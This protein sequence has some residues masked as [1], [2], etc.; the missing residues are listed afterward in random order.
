[1][2]MKLLVKTLERVRSVVLHGRFSDIDLQTIISVWADHADAIASAYGGSGA[3]KSDFT[4]TNERTRK[5][6]LEDGVKS[7]VRYLK[8][9]YFDGPRQVRL[10]LSFFDNPIAERKQDGFDLMTGVYVPR[11]SPSLSLFLIT[12]T[13]PLLTRSVSL[14]PLV[15]S[16]CPFD[17]I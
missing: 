17:V 4:R 15:V 11:K 9:N 1:M 13:R 3:L 16:E 12:D 8:N 14:P 5:G 10:I 7:T 6:L 2:I